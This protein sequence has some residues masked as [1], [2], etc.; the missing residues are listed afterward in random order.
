MKDGVEGHDGGDV[1][2]RGGTKAKEGSGVLKG[3]R[4]MR[5]MERNGYG[6]RDGEMGGWGG[7][8][9]E[10]MASRRMEAR[11]GWWGEGG[12]INR[13]VGDERWTRET[14]KKVERGRK[15]RG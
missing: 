9:G 11:R 1:R 5:G 6:T 3:E 12:A 14:E 10:P 8:I 2:E 4:G 7:G 13:S 15:F